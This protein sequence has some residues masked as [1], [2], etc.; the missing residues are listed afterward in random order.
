[1]EQVTKAW[2]EIRCFRS[3]PSAGSGGRRAP[4][5]SSLILSCPSGYYLLIVV[6]QAEGGRKHRAIEEYEQCR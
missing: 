5:S 1:M 3:L 6:G 4:R 2:A